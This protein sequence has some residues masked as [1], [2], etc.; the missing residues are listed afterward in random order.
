MQMIRLII[1]LFVVNALAQSDLEA[2]GIQKDRSGQVLDSYDSKSLASDG[3]PQNWHHGAF[4]EGHVTTTFFLVVG[5]IG[6]FSFVAVSGLIMFQNLSVSKSQS[7]GIVSEVSSGL[8]QLKYLDLH[9]N[10]FSG[11]VTK[12]LSV[13]VSLMYY[14]NVSSNSLVGELFLHDGTT[15]IKSLEVF[16]ASNNR[17]VDEVPSFN[18]VVSSDSL[19]QKQPVVRFFAASAVTGEFYN[20]VYL[21]QFSRGPLPQVLGTY[22]ELK[23]IGLS[24]NQLSGTLFPSLFSSTKFNDLNLC[25][26]LPWEINRFRNLVYLDLPPNYFEGGLPNNLLDEL[27]GFNVSYNNFSGNVPEN[28]RRFPDSPLHPGNSLLVSPYAPKSP[29]GLPDRTEL[30]LLQMVGGAYMIALLCFLISSSRKKKEGEDLKENIWK[31]GHSLED[32]GAPLSSVTSNPDQLPYAQMG[33]SPQ[34]ESNSSVAKVNVDLSYVERI[35]ELVSSPRSLSSSSNPLP[36][37]EPNVLKVAGELLCA[38][39]E[40]TGGSCHETSCK[41][42]L[43]PGHVLVVK[44]LR[45]GIAKGRKD[46]TREVKKLGSIKLPNL[47]PIQ[48]YYG[49]EHLQVHGTRLKGFATKTD[50]RKLSP[51]SLDTRLRITVYVVCCLNFLH[52]KKGLPHSNLKS[53]NILLEAQDLNALVTDYSLHRLMML[54]GTTKQVLSHP[55]SYKDGVTRPSFLLKYAASNYIQSSL[56]KVPSIALLF[57]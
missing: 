42:T 55:K 11:D 8:D 50:P 18:F 49:G 9:G 30:P 41:A 15:H 35:E 27:Q 36:S 38:P 5:L 2:K 17:L 33:F 26:S 48:G 47:F 7:T 31:T 12:L 10:G 39:A 57:Y 16:D 37:N 53:T 19:A 56:P 45:K 24:F 43:H 22:P 40:V 13:F 28:S 6:K 46:F 4:S 25:G 20:L 44:W 32:I 29:E 51:S 14:Q 54:S 3:C 52:N 23:V 1:C 34:S 21:G